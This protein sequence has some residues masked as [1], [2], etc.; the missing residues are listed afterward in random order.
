[1][2]GDAT[3]PTALSRSDAYI[4]ADPRT[5]IPRIDT[6]AN[7][8][9]GPQALARAL[10]RTV[11]VTWAA[12]PLACALNSIGA[13]VAICTAIGHPNKARSIALELKCACGQGVGH[14]YQ[15]RLVIHHIVHQRGGM[16]CAML[17]IREP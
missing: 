8:G 15:M 7:M 9:V 1:M 16:A 4:D 12:C 17:C 5:G 3:V 11:P 2:S 14:P 10:A 13:S 6:G